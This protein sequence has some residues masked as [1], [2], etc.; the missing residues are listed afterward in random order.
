MYFGE[1]NLGIRVWFGKR[2]REDLVEIQENEKNQ[3]WYRDQLSDPEVL[4]WVAEWYCEHIG[5][6]V[7]GHSKD[8]FCVEDIHNDERV[9]YQC[10]AVHD[11]C[12][13]VVRMAHEAVKKIKEATEYA[14]LTDWLEALHTGRLTWSGP[15]EKHGESFVEDDQ[16][17]RTGARSRRVRWPRMCRTCGEEFRIEKG[18]AKN[19]E[20]CRAKKRPARA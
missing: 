18:N 17:F 19:C 13:E 16:T 20:S 12:W 11:K 6:F 5:E 8:T 2:V 7:R 15:T 3:Y 10:D 1:I 14:D 4:E 9:R